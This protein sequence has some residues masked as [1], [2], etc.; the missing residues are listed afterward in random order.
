MIDKSA[1]VA[2]GPEFFK[3]NATVPRPTWTNV[4]TSVSFQSVYRSTTSTIQ[5]S[6]PIRKNPVLWYS[7]FYNSLSDIRTMVRDLRDDNT[8]LSNPAR[9][10]WTYDI[11]RSYFSLLKDL[12]DVCCWSFMDFVQ[13]T[14]IH[15]YTKETRGR[16]SKS[17]EIIQSCACEGMSLFHRWERSSL[18]P[19]EG[20][21]YPFWQQSSQLLLSKPLI[22]FIQVLQNMTLWSSIYQYDLHNLTAFFC[23]F[24]ILQAALLGLPFSQTLTSSKV[25]IK[26][27][28]GGTPFLRSV[29]EKCHIFFGFK[30]ANVFRSCCGLNVAIKNDV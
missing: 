13:A 28:R 14:C 8:R 23:E 17:A 16:R 7:V 10:T 22:F 2:L 26:L 15:L 1:L 9:D 21:L 27:A 29:L 4:I 11:Y 18:S 3:E 30:Y 24:I 19:W 6:R 20:C 25:G 5:H 12:L